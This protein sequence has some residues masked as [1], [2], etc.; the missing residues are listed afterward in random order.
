MCYMHGV[1]IYTL[2]SQVIM[3]Y[4][5]NLASDI[6]VSIGSGTLGIMSLPQPMQT[7]DP[8]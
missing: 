4:W 8:L 6:L 7:I 5:S 2:N 1:E 3:T